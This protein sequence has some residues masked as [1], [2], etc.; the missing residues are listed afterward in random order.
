MIKN[1]FFDFDG[2]IA[3][4]VSVKTDAFRKLYEEYGE[5][6]ANKVV[7]HHLV[8]G[9]MSRFEK[10]KL[11]H[12]E[13]LGIVIDESSIQ[14][15]SYQF[16]KLVKQG[17]IDAPEVKGSHE[18]LKEFKNQFKMFVIT[19]TPTDE[20]KEICKERGII[21]CFKGIYG[22]PEKKGYWSKYLL[23]TNDLKADETIFVGDAMAD[24]LAAKENN[25]KFYLRFNYEN[26]MIFENIHDTVRFGDFT[27][28]RKK[29]NI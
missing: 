23:E 4:S 26:S 16:S 10:F 27:E 7:K 28:F 17:V 22:S 20:S 25:L 2:V 9:G 29:I 21:D 14:E 19:G 8:N 18:F 15:L 24:Y 6:V 12:R 3:D 1:I 13:F 5:E 11:Y